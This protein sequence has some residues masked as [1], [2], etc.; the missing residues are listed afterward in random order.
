MKTS[1]KGWYKSCFYSEN[2][3][4]SFPSFVGRLLEY[5]GSWVDEPILVVLPIVAALANWVS[6]LKRRSLIGVCMA[7]NWL[8]RRVTPL[9]KQV[10]PGWEYNGLQDPTRETSDNLRVNEVVKLL[11]EMFSNTSSWPIAKQV[12]VYHLG[13]E[14]DPVRQ[15]PINW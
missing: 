5:N 2:H 6:D 12:R 9:K 15:Y 8:A 14:R 4:P 3:E 7:T 11:Q 13:V 1:I 10:H